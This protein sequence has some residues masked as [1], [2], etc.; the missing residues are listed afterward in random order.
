MK[1]IPKISA[2]TRLSVGIVLALAGF[3]ANAA[4]DPVAGK[5]AFADQCSSCHTI[6]PNANGFGPSLSGVVGRHAGAVANFAYSAAMASSKL[7]WQPADID[8]FLTSTTTKVPGTSMPV[9]I[10]DAAMRANIIA[11]LGTL[12]A[13]PPLKA[14]DAAPAALK[15]GPTDEELA[16]AAKDTKSWLYASKDYSGQR[17]VELKQITPANAA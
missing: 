2:T 1:I 11:Y 8:A 16:N 4:G 9:A 13:L 6:D 17:Y 5:S 10:P 14:A 15:H 7:V 12:K 3:S